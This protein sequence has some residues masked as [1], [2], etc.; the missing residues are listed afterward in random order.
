MTSNE[1][2]IFKQSILDD[3]RVMMQT[4]GQVTQYIGARYVPLF[5]DPLEWSDAIE[6]EPLTIVLYQGNSYTS[7][8]FVPRGI[9]ISDESFWANTGNYNAQIEQYRQEVKRFDNRIATNTQNIAENRESI[10]SEISRAKTQETYIINNTINK[11]NKILLIGDSWV[12]IRGSYG[13]DLNNKLKDVINGEVTSIGAS[14][15][16]WLKQGINNETFVDCVN[17][18]LEIEDKNTYDC[19]IFIGGI[20]DEQPTSDNANK[21]S[22]LMSNNIKKLEKAFKHVHYILDSTVFKFSDYYTINNDIFTG[23]RV[24]NHSSVTVAMDYL[25]RSMFNPTDGTHLTENGNYYLATLINAVAY[26]GRVPNF[27]YKNEFDMASSNKSCHVAVKS[28]MHATDGYVHQEWKITK[29]VNLEGNSTIQ[30]NVSPYP[31]GTPISFDAY[32]VSKLGKP[33]VLSINYDYEN[34]NVLLKN[35]GAEQMSSDDA[36]VFE[37]DYY[38]R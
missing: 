35:N 29:A 25:T 34:F 36:I 7:R 37:Y 24:G 9:N 18:A 27:Q 13:K 15:A 17:R 2:E 5:A 10:T 26:G 4:T 33:C 3:V 20:N 11:P 22:E 12:D 28:S 1:L 14:G 19:V 30:Q 8:Q 16:G 32:G 31:M 38:Y 21:I 23:S 6:Y